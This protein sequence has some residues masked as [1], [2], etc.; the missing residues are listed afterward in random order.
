VVSAGKEEGKDEG[1]D[2]GREE[3]KEKGREVG[4][5]GA[6][7]RNSALNT[8]AEKPGLVGLSSRLRSLAGQG[9]IPCITGM[10]P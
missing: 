6:E 5:Q 7:G 3:G 10:Q 9:S 4:R 8:P 2:E 1:K